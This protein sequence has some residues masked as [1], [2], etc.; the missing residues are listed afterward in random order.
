MKLTDAHRPSP[1][2][3][4]TQVY[5]Y[6]SAS[7]DKVVKSHQEQL[8]Q[9]FYIRG[10]A[11]EPVDATDP[12]NR[13]AR[14]ALFAVSGLRAQYPQVFL[15][16]ADGRHTFLGQFEAVQRLNERDELTHDWR[17]TFKNVHPQLA[18]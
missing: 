12:A 13:E 1:A 7:G 9:L 10:L 6:T 11:Y 18:R 16:H 14:N 15:R 5:L 8:E 2:A 17:E 4:P 3:P